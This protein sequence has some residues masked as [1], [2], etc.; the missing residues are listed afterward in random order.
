MFL[1]TKPR[2]VINHVLRA[3]PHGPIR[4]TM[5]EDGVLYPHDVVPCQVRPLGGV[6]W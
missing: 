6:R 2:V 5:A 3:R 1:G 4:V